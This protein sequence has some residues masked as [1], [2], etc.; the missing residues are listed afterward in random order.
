MNERLTLFNDAK[1][2]C[3]KLMLLY[4][5]SQALLSISRQ[6]EYLIG[7]ESGAHGDRSRL[8]EIIIGALTAREVEPLDEDA[9]SVFYKVAGEATRM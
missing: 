8:K 6:I 7:L 4:P 2:R 5:D 3:A 9:A 1:E